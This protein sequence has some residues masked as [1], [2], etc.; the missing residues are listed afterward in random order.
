MIIPQSMTDISGL[1]AS[2]TSVIAK[3]NQN[4]SA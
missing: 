4:K 1:I 2:A 3:A